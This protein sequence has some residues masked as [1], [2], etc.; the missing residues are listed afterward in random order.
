MLSISD[1]IFRNTILEWFALCGELL[2]L[3]RYSRAG[4]SKDFVLI[5]DLESFDVMLSRLPTETNVIVFRQPQLYL[6]GIVDESFIEKALGEI[7]D[8]LEYLALRIDNEEHP[9]SFWTAGEGRNALEAT[10]QDWRGH[11][12]AIG[13]YPTWLEGNRDVLSGI[14]PSADGMLQRGVY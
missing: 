5:D 12:I 13:P 9:W 11:R 6:R 8:D 2:A 4:G 1:D 14:V 10:L 7:R 3:I